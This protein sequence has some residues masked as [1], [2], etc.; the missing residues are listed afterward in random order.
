MPGYV[1]KGLKINTEMVCSMLSE[2]HIGCVKG[3]DNSNCQVNPDLILG[4]LWHFHYL[5]IFHAFLS[6]GPW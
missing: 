6:Q 4:L 5:L 2:S 3:Y 1:I